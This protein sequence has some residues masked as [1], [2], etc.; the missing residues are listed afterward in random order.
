VI[1]LS[2]GVN[3]SK[4]KCNLD[5][6]LYLGSKAPS[7]SSLADVICFQ[8]QEKSSC[9]VLD[10]QKSCCSDNLSNTCSIYTESIKFDFETIISLFDFDFDNSS[11][12]SSILLF[13]DR[14]SECYNNYFLYIPPAEILKPQ[15]SKIQVFLL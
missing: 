4:I 10:V 14:L 8:E 6:T 2:L 15:L 9:C 11:L 5:G 3:V 13:K 12:I 7:C 1:F